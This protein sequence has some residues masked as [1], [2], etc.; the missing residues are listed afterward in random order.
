MREYNLRTEP[1]AFIDIRELMVSQQ[2]NEHGTAIVCG[3]IEDEQEEEYVRLLAKDVWEKIEVIGADGEAETLFWGL[4]IG[5]TIEETF[6]H[7][8]MTLEL[9]TGTYLMDLKTHFRT[10]QD[11]S[12]TYE[13]IYQQLTETYADSDFIKNG[14]LETPIKGMV[15]QHK[16][17]DWELLKRLSGRHHSFLVPAVRVQGTKYFYGLPKP[18]KR[19]FSKSARYTV[20]K[21]MG[22]YQ[23]KRNRGLWELNES[24]CMEYI[25][26]SRECGQL[27]DQVDINGLSL[28]IWK[29][30]SRYEREELI[31]IC[32]LKMKEGLV[33]EEPLREERSGCSFLAEVI[34][35]Q[36]DK[37]MVKV[38]G[39]ENQEQNINLWY[40][41]STVYSSPDG[42]GWYCMPE[43]GDRVRLHIP[44]QREE[45]AYV[46]SSVHMDTTSQ[47]RKNPEHKIMKNKYQKEIRFTPD[48]IVITNNQGTKIELNDTTGVNIVSQHDIVIKAKD[49]LT[50]S[51]ET[52]ALTAAGTTSVNLKQKTTSIDISKGIS[53]TGGELKVQ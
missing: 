36:E 46:I 43:I 20:K 41:Y 23:R 8:S 29:I 13:A 16:E 33:V 26:E 9:V 3:Y 5:F 51:S 15:L 4:V 22:D 48:S 7:K 50:I 24:S 34:K 11:G 53:F 6:G 30:E 28:F 32:H 35:V 49:N 1:L 45:D 37:V 25:V 17:T 52:G 10:F 19:E 44:E 18:G 38:F 14:S 42:T 21:D 12:M 39:D 2:I 31:H 27:G 47:E 40:P